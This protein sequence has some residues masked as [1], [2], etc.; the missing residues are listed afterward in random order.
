MRYDITLT[1]F[2]SDFNQEWSSVLDINSNGSSYDQA[3]MVIQDQA[4]GSYYALGRTIYNFV[5]FSDYQFDI[6]TAKFD[7]NGSNIFSSIFG[8]ESFHDIPKF[9]SFNE[10]NQLSIFALKYTDP[11][12]SW[13]FKIDKDGIRTD[14]TF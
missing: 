4:D 12:E 10:F 1:K 13:I 7:V 14:K 9:I 11:K 5:D 8:N 2:D 3:T 6:F